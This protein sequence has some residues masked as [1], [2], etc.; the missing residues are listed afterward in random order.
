[1]F[2][3]LYFFWGLRQ[4]IFINNKDCKKIRCFWLGRRLNFREWPSIHLCIFRQNK[5]CLTVELQSMTCK[6]ISMTLDLIIEFKI[7]LRRLQLPVLR[8]GVWLE[9]GR[10]LFCAALSYSISLLRWIHCL[11]S[12]GYL[13][14]G[15]EQKQLQ[16]NLWFVHSFC[17]LNWIWF[18]LIRLENVPN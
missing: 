5:G 12:I 7:A 2:K 10:R 11:P 9:S 1:M 15:V 3:G 14:N 8:N 4:L 18:C 13:S 16:R 6:K 17:L